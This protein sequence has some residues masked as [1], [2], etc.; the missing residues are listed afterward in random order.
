MENNEL[1]KE[2]IL[3]KSGV[4]PKKCM[5]CV[6]CSATCPNYDAMAWT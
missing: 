2:I 3:L 6:K 1:A 4:N 5:V